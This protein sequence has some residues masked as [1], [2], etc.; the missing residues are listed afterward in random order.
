MN[1]NMKKMMFDEKKNKE[2]FVGNEKV[3]TF[4]LAKQ[5]NACF[6]KGNIPKAGPFVYRL[7]REIFIL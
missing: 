6:A 2:S 4:A 1:E 5:N 7:G 3:R